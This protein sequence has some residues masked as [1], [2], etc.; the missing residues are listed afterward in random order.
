VTPIGLATRLKIVPDPAA[1]G[2]AVEGVAKGVT[3]QERFG[4]E[5]SGALLGRQ[6]GKA[7]SV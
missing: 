5:G 4:G 1:A 3:G 6:V 7:K 2:D